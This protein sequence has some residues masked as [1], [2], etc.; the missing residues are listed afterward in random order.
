MT[1]ETGLQTVTIQILPNIPSS[2]GNQP[3][4]EIRSDNK[5]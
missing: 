3:V 2:K 1:L 5:L 4:N